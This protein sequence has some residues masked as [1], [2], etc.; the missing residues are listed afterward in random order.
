M[1]GSKSVL[2]FVLGLGLAGALSTPAMA[3]QGGGGFGGQRFDPAA[4]R[5]R[6]LQRI[7]E[8]CGATDDEWKVL[9]PKITR[10]METQQASRTPFG[11]RGRGPGGLT[12]DAGPQ[13]P[14]A[15]AANDL[16]QS[17][18]NKD[19]TPDQIKA[20]L[21]ALREAREKAAAEAKAAQAEL[22][23]LLTARQE[24]VLVSQGILD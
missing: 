8:S 23:E 2:I 15:V 6:M 11:G 21:Q 22:R 3:Q 9:E 10:V 17:L 14:V 24:A 20:K 18:D 16:R 12:P 5:D 4:M 7:K 1:F 19:T 13:S